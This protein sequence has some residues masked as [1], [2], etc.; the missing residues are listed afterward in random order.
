MKLVI[1]VILTAMT[2]QSRTQ[3]FIFTPQ[4]I[5]QAQFASY[6]VA[7]GKGFYH[8]AGISS[9]S[10]LVESDVFANLGRCPQITAWSR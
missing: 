10:K 3:K 5:V 9:D 7:H 1:A 2:M 4:W 6:Y 8:K